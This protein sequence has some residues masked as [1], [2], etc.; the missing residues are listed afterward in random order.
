MPS[1][2]RIGPYRFFFYSNEGAEPPHVHVQ[3]EQNLAKFWLA[4]PTLAASIGFA[5]HELRKIERIMVENQV[6][7]L[8]SWREFFNR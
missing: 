4:P 2:G 5:A 8:E 7:F 1:V 3:R 6:S